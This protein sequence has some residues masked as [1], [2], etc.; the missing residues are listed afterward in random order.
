MEVT[1]AKKDIQEQAY[2]SNEEMDQFV[3]LVGTSGL[4][5]NIISQIIRLFDKENPKHKCKHFL[6]ARNEN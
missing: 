2:Y 1:K 5:S 3:S 6:L 4:S